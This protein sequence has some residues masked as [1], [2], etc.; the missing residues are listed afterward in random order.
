LGHEVVEAKPDFSADAVARAF[1]VIWAAGCASTITGIAMG[2][3]VKPTPDQYEPITWGLYEMGIKT[4]GPDYLF[5]V[6]TLQRMARDVA[7]FFLDVDV[8]MTPTLAEPPV[9]LGT[10]DSPPDDLLQGWRRSG[11]FVPY[12]PLCNATGQPAMSVPLYWNG[13]GLP[14]GTHF[15]GRFGDEATLLR[16]ASQL[17]EARPWRDRRPP[18]RA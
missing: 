16:L 5:A 10:F 8:L 9:P 2:T 4:T 7:R 14:V 1:T 3:G 12:T 11:L 6:Q 13:A 15:V 18:V 17:E